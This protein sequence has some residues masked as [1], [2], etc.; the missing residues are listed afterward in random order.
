MSTHVRRC[1]ALF[2]L[3]ALASV[4][5]AE[6]PVEAAATITAPELKKHVEFLADDA[7]EGRGT[8]SAGERA[9]AEYMIAAFR[10]AGLEGG[11]EDGSFLQ[12][13]EVPG[14]ARLE[15]TPALQV[16]VGSWWRD[17]AIDK[18]ARPFGFSGTGAL[19]APLVFAGYG[20][21]DPARGYDDYAGLDVKGKAVLILRHQP[22]PDEG[23]RENAFFVTK[24]R[25][26]RE[27]GAAALLVVNDTLH[28]RDDGLAPFGGAEDAGLPAFH[29]TRKV[30]SSLFQ[31]AGLD[32]AAIQRGIDEG[33]RPA[34]RELPGRVKLAVKVE[35]QLLRPRNVIARLAGSDPALAHE[36]VV[37]GAH[38]DHLGR[39]H[40]GQSLAPGA[41]DEIHNGADDNASGTAGILELAQAMA[42]ARPKRTVYFVGFSG[43]EMG[44]LGSE[45]FVKHPPIDLKRV[46]AMINLDMI[47]R[48]AKERLE[49]GGVGSSPGFT[50]LVKR[51][52][53]PEGFQLKLTRSGFG[54][55]DHASFYGAG[56]PVLFFFTGLHGDYHRPSDDPPTVDAEG[57]QR[58]A[59]AAFACALEL[60]NAPERPAYVAPPPRGGR[61]RPRLGVMLDQER[62]ADGAGVREVVAGGPAA[63]AGVQD[64]DVIVSLGG[65]R[66][67]HSEDL[68]E[69]LGEHK[70][71][72]EVEVVVLRGQEQVT[73]TVKLGGGR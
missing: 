17:L 27:R 11:G 18:E 65:R 72:D 41:K 58:V 24:A 44:L 42:A 10:A 70:P 56:V 60:A 53:E 59:R 73:L 31:L 37:I 6:G 15:G 5:R 45:Y 69:A 30:A 13:F 2:A 16:Q 4:L 36:V 33:L 62:E 34:S 52:C 32:L 7:R 40:T 51:V 49:V 38:Y 8:G 28:Q 46:V 63:T 50:E 55:S 57:M 64:G 39:G 48:L 67:D 20:V 29:V 23:A 14:D 9:A 71:G 66:I 26:A 1:G 19:E 61:N 3:L 35:R 21:V 47:G 54:P 43:E 22:R 25:L 12:P 68:L